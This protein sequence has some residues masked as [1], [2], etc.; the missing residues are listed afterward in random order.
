MVLPLDH[1]YHDINDGQH[2]GNFCP[3]IDAD[4]HG[5]LEEKGCVVVTNIYPAKL[6][7]N[8]GEII[9]NSAGLEDDD[10]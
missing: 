3:V 5:V 4:H 6:D 9:N 1:H 10:E 8:F 7:P 2:E